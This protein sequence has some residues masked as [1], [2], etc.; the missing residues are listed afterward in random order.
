[1]DRVIDRFTLEE[2]IS[3]IGHTESDLQGIIDM[4]NAG[5]LELES[6]EALLRGV[7]E[8]TGL[9]IDKAMSTLEIMIHEGTI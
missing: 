7:I 8:M 6:V 5:E 4:I 9:R 1:M 3:S 2:D